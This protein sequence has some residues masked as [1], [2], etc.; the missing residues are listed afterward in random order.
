MTVSNK[1]HYV[2]CWCRCRYCWSASVLYYCKQRT[3]WSKCRPAV[4]RDFVSFLFS[5]LN[6][7]CFLFFSFFIFPTAMFSI[8]N[9]P[10]DIDG[11]LDNRWVL[12]VTHTPVHAFIYRTFYLHMINS[13]MHRSVV[14]P[15]DRLFMPFVCQSIEMCVQADYS[16][17]CWWWPY[18]SFVTIIIAADFKCGN[19]QKQ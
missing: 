2:L 12:A 4:S 1:N 14:F 3:K 19:R 17:A 9:K 6:S 15:L 8:F 5:S 7:L 13:I 11:L 10:G 16:I 18:S